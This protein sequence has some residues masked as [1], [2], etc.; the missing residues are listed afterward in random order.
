VVFHA[1]FAPVSIERGKHARRLCPGFNKIFCLEGFLF[2]E[3]PTGFFNFAFE[4]Q[5]PGSWIQAAVLCFVTCG[6]FVSVTTAVSVS[7]MKRPQ[8]HSGCVQRPFPNGYQHQR[9]FG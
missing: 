8:N 3:V 1:C 5:A 9:P 4:K 6:S 7:E 2:L